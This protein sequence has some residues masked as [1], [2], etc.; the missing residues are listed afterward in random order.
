MSR[1]AAV[2]DRHGDV[3]CPCRIAVAARVQRR[4]GTSAPVGFT[5]ESMDGAPAQGECVDASG[6]SG[7]RRRPG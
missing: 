4:D 3:A 6:T 5:V 7:P 2:C 1:A